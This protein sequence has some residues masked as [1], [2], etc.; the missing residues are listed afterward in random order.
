M[1]HVKSHTISPIR[2]PI[3]LVLLLLVS[4]VY[5]AKAQNSSGELLFDE[6]YVHEIRMTFSDPDFWD[7]LTE[8]YNDTAP[9]LD[10]ETGELIPGGEK[11]YVEASL[12]ID[13]N[14]LGIVGLRQKGFFSNWGA[15]GSLKKPLKIDFNEFVADTEYD[16]LKK[17]NLQNGFQDPS[18]MRDA[19]AYKLFRD[20]EI[21]ASRTAYARL[22]LNDSYWGLYL[23]VEQIDKTF[24]AENF[25]SN[26]G[27]LYKCMGNTSLEW[28]GTDFNAYANEFDL[29]TNE[30]ENDWT[31]FIDFVD[32]VNN[33]DAAD[34]ELELANRFVLDDYLKILALDV[35]MNNW[36]SYYGQ[37]RNF[38][39]YHDIDEDKFQW[40]PWDY[41]LSFM[42]VETE[43]LI[44]NAVDFFGENYTEKWL[45]KNIFENENLKNQY[46]QSICDLKNEYFTLAYL[47][48]YIDQTAAI[49][50]TALDEDPN[51]FYSMYDFEN[52]TDERP[53]LKAFIGNRLSEIDA[54]FA[55]LDFDCFG[56]GEEDLFAK[57]AFHYYPNPASGSLYIVLNGSDIEAAEIALYNPLGGLVYTN[58]SVY[59]SLQIE[60]R[61]FAPGVY[62]LKCQ[63][64]DRQWNKKVIL[65]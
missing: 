62:Y 49:I 38:Y 27:N 25:D 1:F 47:E 29:K 55:V 16:G 13:G 11:I 54:E 12:L 60:T 22:Y 3:I 64:G 15:T 34:F 41:N 50:E 63:Q 43:L 42:N 46:L 37:G 56:L 40:I 31:D 36:D 5:N 9:V 59:H 65:Q 26:D 57:Q 8:N 44:G 32:I 39:L 21:P 2:K 61:H 19:I 14:D 52:G 35:M 23:M 58:T 33:S 53:D 51:K 30:T 18:M 17:L 28:Q 45:T 6:S 48:G 7:L 20:N 24:L 10:P 4:A